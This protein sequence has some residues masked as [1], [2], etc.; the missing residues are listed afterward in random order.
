M[1]DNHRNFAYSTVLTAPSPASSGTSL[2]VQNGD[3]GRFPNPPFNATVWPT[4]VQP[5]TSNAEIVRVTA[6]NSD[7]FT[8]TRTQE[9]SSAR[10]VVVGDQIAA[11]V[12]TRTLTD[13]E[14][15]VTFYT[16]FVLGSGAASGLQTLASGSS[17]TST[18][19]LYVF[20][21]T[22]PPNLSFNQILVPHSLS[23]ITSA[24]AESA[25]NTYSYQY[26][27][28]SMNAKTALSLI[29]S[30]SF[31]IGETVDQASLTWNYPT[32]TATSGWGYG[33]FPA[34][35]LT[36]IGQIQSYV[37]STRIFGLQFG[38]NMTLSGGV[39]WLGLLSQRK[40]GAGAHATYGLSNAGV[41]G[42]VINTLNQVG[43]VNGPNP[44][45][46][47]AS[48][49]SATTFNSNMTAWWGRHI[50]GFVTATSITNQAGSAV[51][52]A[53]TLSALADFNANS[54]ATI[55]PAVTFVST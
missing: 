8:I 39:Y 25:S 14:D 49:W 3:G 1:P 15:P 53:I 6:I 50:V 5:L 55:I 43:T 44:I 21:V 28:Y 38:G 48:A 33:S 22:L 32:S 45:G 27:L 51:P 31:S 11:T 17:Q 46:F 18:A 9:S 42:M 35:N 54:T 12:T 37:Q 30:S 34:G 13:A 47:A 2:T 36:G 4:G 52:S 16:P 19:S 24:T 23:Y 20:P 10:S 41:I 40:T 26:G 7:T 29:S